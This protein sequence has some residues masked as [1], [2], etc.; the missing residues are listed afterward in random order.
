MNI[1]ELL[2]ELTLKEIIELAKQQLENER[3]YYNE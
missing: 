2:Q 1:E 3:H